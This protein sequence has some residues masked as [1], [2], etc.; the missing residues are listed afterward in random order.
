MNYTRAIHRSLLAASLVAGGCASA[1]PLP[2]K[3]PS[4][5]F[6]QKM[7]WMLQLEDRRLLRL[8]PPL[9][10]APPAVPA[11]GR[12][13][14]P[15]PAP[16]PPP[17]DLTNL[18]ADTEPRVR[19]RA[20]LAIGRVGLPAG[21]QPLMG[22]LSDADPEVREMAAFALGLIGRVRSESGRHIVAG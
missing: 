17:V 11:K 8:E 18:L 13:V 3:P 16:A 6:E 19:R 20:A 1:P 12:K 22:A 15:A 10:P 2:V 14:A 9:A 4:I 5:P 7:S 21:V